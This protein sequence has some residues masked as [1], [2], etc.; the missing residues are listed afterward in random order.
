MSKKPTYKELDQRIK[1]LEKEMVQRDYFEKQLGFLSLAVEQSSEGI[2]VVDLDGNLQY[3]NS[4][5]AEMHGYFPEELVGK[6]L[7]IF[8]TPEQIPHIEAA[9][10]ELK[11]KGSFKGEVWHV[12]RDGSV[13]P[14]L[15]HNSLIRDD[16]GKPIGMMGTLRD[17]TDIK[18]A[19]ELLQKAHAELEKRV[20]E[21]TVELLKTNER[22]KESEEYFRILAEGSF[23]SS[24][25][26]W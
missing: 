26:R 18:Q 3:L 9:N 25:Y 24:L 16:T 20:E 11:Q 5:F 10:L 12:K 8:H 7:S 14:T 21:R 19:E 23:V 17:I 15:M 4:V 6:K 1:E 13:F 2:A 22:L